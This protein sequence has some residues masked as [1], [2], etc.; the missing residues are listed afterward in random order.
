VRHFG[1]DW[2]D[3]DSLVPPAQVDP[4]SVRAGAAMRHARLLF[5]ISVARVART[6]FS[7]IFIL[8]GLLAV[9]NGV[10]AET[11]VVGVVETVRLRPGDVMVDAKIDTGADGSSLDA[12]DIQVFEQNGKRW[13]RFKIVDRNG[14]SVTLERPIVR[15]IRIRRAEVG[16]SERPV[17]RLRLCIGSTDKEINVNLVDRSRL[18]YPMLIG[19]RDLAGHALVDPSRDHLTSPQ[20]SQE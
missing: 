18:K 11:Q 3:G 9:R 10:A 13:T 16:T 20:C 6:A 12:R 1:G 2:R 4:L 19:R 17:V 14:Q 15:M 8:I 5:D 7:L